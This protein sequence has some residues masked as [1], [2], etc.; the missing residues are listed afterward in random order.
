[1]TTPAAELHYL[2]KHLH[3][4][5]GKPYGLTPHFQRERLVLKDNM[6]NK[7]KPLTLAEA[8]KVSNGCMYCGKRSIRWKTK[9]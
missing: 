6:K 5:E 1:M 8:M 4:M 9:T 3:E 7:K 2:H